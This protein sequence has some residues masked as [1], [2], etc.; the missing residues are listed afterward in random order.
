MKKDKLKKELE[1]LK[2]TNKYAY[3]NYGSELCSGEM[4][5]KE[6]ELKQKINGNIKDKF[7]DKAEELIKTV[8]RIQEMSENKYN[9]MY[10]STIIQSLLQK[11]IKL[12]KKEIAKILRGLW[13]KE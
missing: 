7:D 8:K 13:R 3:E 12:N 2:E 1:E 10:V 5:R 11:T 9:I 6:E 4:I